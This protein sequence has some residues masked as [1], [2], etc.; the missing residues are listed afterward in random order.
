MKKGR[1]NMRGWGD[2]CLQSWYP[3]GYCS[4]GGEYAEL[5]ELSGSYFT[6][7]WT[8]SSSENSSHIRIMESVSAV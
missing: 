8:L 5:T 2:T 6:L 7:Y 4:G 1:E 3:P